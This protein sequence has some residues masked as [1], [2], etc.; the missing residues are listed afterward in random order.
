MNERSGLWGA[1]Y[2]RVRS[3]KD[4]C[5]SSREA[6]TRPSTCQCQEYSAVPRMR[7]HGTP[8][9]VHSFIQKLFMSSTGLLPKLCSQWCQ[10]M[11]P[12][13]SLGRACGAARTLKIV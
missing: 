5:D 4:N 6:E 2:F 13:Q 9:M 12:F 3:G 1:L 7:E 8:T 11:K 10:I